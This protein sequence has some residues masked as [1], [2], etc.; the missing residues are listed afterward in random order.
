M[1]QALGDG[2]LVAMLGY[3]GLCLKIL[4]TGVIRLGDA[5]TVVVPD[6]ISARGRAGYC[7]CAGLSR[8]E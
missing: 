3:G 5:V 2:G 8:A 6:R 4:E 7:R 1:E